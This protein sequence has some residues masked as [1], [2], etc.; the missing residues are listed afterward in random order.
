[1]IKKVAAAMAV[2]AVTGYAA[3][4][5]ADGDAAK[6]EKV[7]KKCKVCHMVGDNAKN[8]VGP[9][10]NGIV[11]RLAGSAPGY[12]YSKS[13]EAKKDAGMHWTKENL[14]TFL[15]KP[16]DFVPGTKM[17]FAGLSNEH[18]RED[19]IAYLATFN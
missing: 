16:K 11:G 12:H 4:A 17:G 5:L 2:L 10:L 14:D 3:T 6:G 8:R 19:V 1:M 7:F 13:M 9:E 15:K 18:D